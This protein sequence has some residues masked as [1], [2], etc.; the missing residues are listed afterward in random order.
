[1]QN[2]VGIG[3]EMLG[4]TRSKPEKSI[5][6]PNQARLLNIPSYRKDK[7]H[8]PIHIARYSSTLFLQSP[9]QVRTF[10]MSRPDLQSCRWVTLSSVFSLAPYRVENAIFVQPCPTHYKL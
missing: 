8:W 5:A 3:P 1:L 10:F 9:N 4:L 7:K 6:G 2:K